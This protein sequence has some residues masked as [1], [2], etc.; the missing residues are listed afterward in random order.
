MASQDGI[1]IDFSHYRIETHVE[2]ALQLADSRAFGREQPTNALDWLVAAAT[3]SSRSDA[4]TAIGKLI[5]LEPIVQ[6]EPILK[7]S[8]EYRV[9]R[10]LSESLNTAKPFLSKRVWG[11]DFITV[12][13][14]SGDPNLNEYLKSEGC[15]PKTVQQE[16]FEFVMSTD[17]RRPR[18]QWQAWRVTVEERSAPASGTFERTAYLLTW[19]PEHYSTDSLHSYAEALV[20]QGYVDMGWS[21]GNRKN[22][23]TGSRVYLL[24]QDDNSGL[25]GRGE[26]LSLPR[27]EPHWKPKEAAKGKKSLIVQV[28][29][30]RLATDPLLGI[31]E[32]QKSTGDTRLWQTQAGG[33]VIPKTV[34][35][36]LQTLL[37]STTLEED[38]SRFARTLSDLDHKNDW[39]GVRPDVEALSTVVS[40]NR[41]EPP[42]S[43]AIFGDWGSGKTFLMRKIQE[44]VT[45][46]EQIGKKQQAEFEA[47]PDPDEEE[48]ARYCSSIL[49]IEFNAWHYTESNLW[50]SLLNHIFEK[51][52][53]KLDQESAPDGTPSAEEHVETLFKELETARTARTEYE[54]NLKKIE[55]ATKVAETALTSAN[56]ELGMSEDA[57]RSALSKKAWQLV[58]EVL[59]TS[60][61]PQKKKLQSALEELGLNKSVQ[62]AQSVYETVKRFRSVSGRAQQVLGSLLATRHG[63]NGAFAVAVI[64]GL[65]LLLGHWFNMSGLPFTATLMSA[66]VWIGERAKKVSSVLSNI[67]EADEWLT[68]LFNSKQTEKTAEVETARALLKQRQTALANA[69]RNLQE[70]LESEATAKAELEQLT[71]R[72]QMR[73]FV[74]TRIAE[75][76]YSKHLG[77]VSMIRRDFEDLSDFMYRDRQQG[78]SRLVKRIEEKTRNSIPTVERIILYI[79]DLDRCQPD[80]VVEVL[81]AVH[82]LMAFRLFVV[83]VAV[84]PRW[85]FKSL[86]KR[87]PHLASAQVANNTPN[88]DGSGAEEQA[89]THDYIEKIFHIPFWVKPMTPNACKDLVAGYFDFTRGMS[90]DDAELDEQ[91]QREQE[92][93]HEHGGARKA[94]ESTVTEQTSDPETRQTLQQKVETAAEQRIAERAIMNVSISKDEQECIETLAPHLGNS[95]RRIK[96]FANIYRLLKSG[97]SHTEMLSFSGQDGSD[98]DYRAVLIFLAV[99]TGAPTLAPVIL[100]EAYKQRNEFNA[101]TLIND[102]MVSSNTNPDEWNNGK[103]ALKLL[104]G[105]GIEAKTIELW[106]PRVMRYGFNLTPI[107]TTEED[108]DTHEG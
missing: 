40:V 32:L 14:L 94:Q 5:P 61:D 45:L 60:N 22:L 79:D 51:L 24:R 101:D 99:V 85:V 86:K 53:E 70:A 102:L 27:K 26:T 59:A 52:Q 48:P 46:L 73:R 55:S 76:G 50:A 98:K 57:L 23:P 97:L 37:D 71:A 84:D 38:V 88:A 54:A 62:S 93:Y 104:S 4:F 42:L 82:L 29:W 100:A 74:D 28:R 78:E 36:T 91:E 7:R 103:G 107:D 95:P 81:E 34:A 9:T 64:A 2:H 105:I 58:D 6:P 75:S 65:G 92:R 19:N 108:G 49:Q 3:V 8:P 44:R 12:A 25:V 18:E 20:S 11:R 56:E 1:L 89:S 13:L 15:D 63:R 31:D 43:I 16:W 39:I 41:L 66:L 72:D 10:A 87:Y 96:R 80:R 106:A 90:E 68:G 21:S 33:I 69:Q 83:V 67:Q 30:D 35:A 77:L 47:I 17:R